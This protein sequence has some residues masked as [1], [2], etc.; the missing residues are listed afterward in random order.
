[1]GKSLCSLLATAHRPTF[2]N[3]L[4]EARAA[5]AEEQFDVV[6]ADDRLPE[7]Q[8]VE[9][10]ARVRE[11]TPATIRLLMSAWVDPQRLMK[12]INE[13]HVFAFLEKPVTRQQLFSTLAQVSQ[14]RL[15][16][17]ERDEAL[18]DLQDQ[19]DRLETQVKE[20][21]QQLA[22]K[23]VQL[24]HLAMRDPLTSL[25]NRRYIEQ[26]MEEELNRLQRYGAPFSILLFDVDDFKAVN[27]E[28]GH[29]MGDKVLIQVSDSLRNSVR[30]VDLV[31]RFGGEEF[32]V[33]LPNTGLEAAELTGARLCREA[34]AGSAVP[35]ADGRSISITISGGVTAVRA[36]DK[37][38]AAAVARADGALYEAKG[39][40][41]NCTRTG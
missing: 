33:V 28:E 20:R 18:R 9:F 24:E 40:G 29:A 22:E 27:D 38:W 4:D 31:A 17:S 7:P 19:K 12:A 1:M 5:L 35:S 2:A 14:M 8:G 3:T 39:A 6:L 41:K 36:D 11:E 16:M 13:T 25:F 34:A 32:L 10:L 26:R 37:T 30:Q 21:T 15:V 23:N